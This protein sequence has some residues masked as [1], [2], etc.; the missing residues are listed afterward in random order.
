MKERYI[1]LLERVFSAYTYERLQRYKKEVF[2]KGITEHGFAR[3]T[4]NLGFLIAHGRRTDLTKDFLEMMDFCCEDM[5][6][7]DLK[8]KLAKRGGNVF[9]VKEI[10]FCLLE[11][12]KAKVFDKSVTDGWKEKLS[13]IDE[14]LTYSDIA[15]IPPQPLANW[16]VFC[17]ASEQVRKYAGIGGSTE[18]I[19]NQ[20]ASQLTK[21][22]DNGMY[23]DPHGPMVYDSV[24]RL[25]F[26]IALHFGF[27]GKLR[28]WL[29]E[30][31]LK[32]ADPT[33][34]MQSAIGEIPFGGRSNQ[35]LHNDTYWIALCEYYAT[36]FKARGDLVKAG[37]FKRAAEIAMQSVK[38]WLC[39]GEIHHIKNYFPVDSGY[40]CEPYGYFDKY[41]VTAG[42]WLCMAYLFADDSIEMVSPPSE[43]GSYIWETSDFF[44]MVFMKYGDYSVQYDTNAFAPFDSS[45]IGRIHKKGAPPAI[46]LSVPMMNPS[47]DY[48]Y[49]LAPKFDTENDMP[50]SIACGVKHGEK[51][52]YA[53]SSADHYELISKEVTADYVSATF[54]CILEN[55]T[56]LTQIC[57][58]TDSGV[59]LTARSLGEVSI[60]IPALEFDGREHAKITATDK[61]V[62]VEYKGSVC[63]YTTDGTVSGD[64]RIYANKNGH[65]RGYETHAY[66]EVTL[67][68]AIK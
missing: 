22:D 51:F 8:R 3:V 46:T 47:I 12:E 63:C 53:T 42:S 39:E 60:L 68:I 57:R 6:N 27:N 11:L 35:Y 31:M 17:A 28:S 55:G 30:Q 61:S 41:M 56:E 59:E 1:E 32:S 9:T 10:V 2:E 20:I 67:K 4:A 23:R 19:N 40:G 33:L 50:F 16:A 25:Q 24:T 21:F 5:V 58:I 66:G 18:F 45:G 52:T 54:K 15:S 14:H 13:K 62:K 34:L 38:P 48:H 7:I 49:P 37:Q 64:D 43:S 44:H 26:A 36:T 29:E 65:Y